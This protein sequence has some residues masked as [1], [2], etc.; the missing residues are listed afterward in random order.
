MNEKRES[1]K[2]IIAD[3]LGIRRPDD[4]LPKKDLPMTIEH[5]DEDKKTTE[6]SIMNSSDEMI[7]D[8][9][10][11]KDNVQ[12]IITYGDSALAD[13]MELAKQSESPRAYE[14]AASLMKT[15]LDANKDFVVMS[16]RKHTAKE[17]A[18]GGGGSS[19]GPNV[20]NNNLVVSTTDLLK[21]LKGEGG[22]K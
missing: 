16:N 14:V 13:M 10:T 17:E 12:N 8:I 1:K 19:E 7:K 15:L 5:D 4:L 3:T 22:D 11:A 2:N 20:V 21:M 18:K 6:V 9:D